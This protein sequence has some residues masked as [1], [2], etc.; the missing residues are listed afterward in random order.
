MN[1]RT[2]LRALLLALFALGSVAHAQAPEMT[3]MLFG[4]ITEIDGRNVKFLNRDGSSGNISFSPTALT[5]DAT[6]PLAETI[7]LDG[8]QVG[9]IFV[10]ATDASKKTHLVLV[11]N[12]RATHPEW[13]AVFVRI[14]PGYAT[15]HGSNAPTGATTAPPQRPASADVFKVVSYGKVK[16]FT[17]PQMSLVDGNGQAQSVEIPANAVFHDASKP[18]G[19]TADASQIQAGDEILLTA[20]G[21]DAPHVLFLRTGTRLDPTWAQHLTR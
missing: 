2:L 11:R 1:P 19:P 4:K 3:L 9:D 20:D 14:I 16:A 21:A 6:R 7:P 18:F 5:H 15:V 10:L 17:P 13:D 8:A 12:E